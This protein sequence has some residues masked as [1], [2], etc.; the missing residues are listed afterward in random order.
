MTVLKDCELNPHA[1]QDLT[2]SLKEKLY[3]LKKVRKNF[4][5]RM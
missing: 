3:T 4:N 1:L 2:I 5:E